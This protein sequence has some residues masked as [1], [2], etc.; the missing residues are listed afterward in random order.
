MNDTIKAI[1]LGVTFG[2]VAL[3]GIS[4]VGNKFFAAAIAI[5]CLVVAQHIMAMIEEG[6]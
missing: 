1:A 3:T 6:A 2:A 5:V 4:L